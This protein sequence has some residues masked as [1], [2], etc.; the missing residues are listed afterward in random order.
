MTAHNDTGAGHDLHR[1]IH[2]TLLPGF[3]GTPAEAP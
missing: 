3:P 1:D 2:T